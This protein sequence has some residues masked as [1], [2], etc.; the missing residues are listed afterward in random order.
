MAIRRRSWIT[1]QKRRQPLDLKTTKWCDLQNGGQNLVSDPKEPCDYIATGRYMGE[2]MWPT[3]YSLVISPLLQSQE[4]FLY[5]LQKWKWRVGQVARWLF[6]SRRQLSL[7]P[8][9]TDQEKNPP[10]SGF[11]KKN[12]LWWLHLSMVHQERNN[13]LSVFYI[14]LQ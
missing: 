5:F 7:L 13:I 14:H 9:S 12:T 4:H 6:A 1:S 10:T 3:E 11:L 8:V 2:S